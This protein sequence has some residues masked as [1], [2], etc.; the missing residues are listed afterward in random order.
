LLA[1]ASTVSDAAPEGLRSFIGRKVTDDL[2][3]RSDSAA[4]SMAS[5]PPGFVEVGEPVGTLR[6]AVDGPRPGCPDG[7]V[8]LEEP[9]CDDRPSWCSP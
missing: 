5:H 2:L 6:P 8:H 7:P 1:P 3:A 9:T 4:H